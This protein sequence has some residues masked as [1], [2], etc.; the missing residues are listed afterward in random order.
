MSC[1]TRKNPSSLKSTSLKSTIRSFTQSRSLS[2]DY[3]HSRWMHTEKC[4]LLYK[5]E[6]QVLL[7]Y[8]H[9]NSSDSHFSLVLGYT[10]CQWCFQLSL[11]HLGKLL[12]IMSRNAHNQTHTHTLIHTHTRMTYTIHTHTHITHS[13]KS[14]AS[15]HQ[16][17]VVGTQLTITTTTQNRRYKHGQNV[18]Q[19]QQ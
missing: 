8:I 13:S 19:K 5:G 1:N 2:G 4:T 15:P 17:W 3:C 18:L 14:Y 6:L 9:W 11:K 12:L 10:C 7:H 16:M